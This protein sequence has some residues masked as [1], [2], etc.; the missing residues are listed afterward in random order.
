MKRRGSHRARDFGPL[1]D[2][3]LRAVLCQQFS[4]EFGYQDKEPIAQLIVERVLETIAGFTAPATHLVP[5]QVIWMGVPRDG[6]KHAR[7]PMRQTPQ[8]PLVLDLVTAADLAAL[9]DGESYA[10][11]RQR[12]VARLLDQAYAQGGVLAQSDLAALLL[13]STTGVRTDMAV[14]QEAEARHLPHRGTVHDLGPTVSHKVEVARLLEAGY[15]EPEICRRLTPQHSLRAVERYAQTYK[16][17]L[18]LLDQGLAPQ[19]IAGILGLGQ[20][21]LDQYVAMVREHHPE[22]MAQNPHLSSDVEA[23]DEA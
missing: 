16:N 3:T 18:K 19:E 2:K 10:Q 13:R 1:Q 17:T 9:A 4:N 22:I 15:L 7:T 11:L 5:G 23:S 8:M 14:V 21:L 20:R 6:S 12:R